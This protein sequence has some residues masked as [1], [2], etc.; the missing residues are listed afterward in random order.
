MK[1]IEIDYFENV[2][3]P[4]CKKVLMGAEWE[5]SPAKCEH[6]IFIATDTCFEY[7][8]EDMNDLIKNQEEVSYDSYTDSLPIDGIRF[9]QYAPAPNYFGVYFGLK[10]D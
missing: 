7:I 10:K 8:R 9:A 6:T 3:C 1:N 2:V 5:E 4:F